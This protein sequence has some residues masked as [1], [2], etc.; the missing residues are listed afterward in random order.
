MN[1][2]TKRRGETGAG[3]IGTPPASD[4]CG[5]GFVAT[6]RGSATRETVDRALE[7]LRRLEH[8]GGR[9]AD[10][11]G[12]GAGIAASIPRPLL[13]A[14]ARAVGMVFLPGAPADA[15][16]AAMVIEDELRRAGMTRVRWRDVPCNNG[17]LGPSARERR[18]LIR[19]V[20]SEPADGSVSEELLERGLYIA[21]RRA[22]R[23]FAAGPAD[24]AAHV[25]S[26]SCRT[27]VYK[28]M[29]GSDELERFY[30]D[31]RD[32]RFESAAAVFH[33]RFS[34]NTAPSWPLVQPL[35]TTAHNGEFNTLAGNVSWLR[36]RGSGLGLG[37]FGDDAAD[38]LPVADPTDSDSATFDRLFELMV[39]SGRPLEAV[40]SIV[41]P[42]PHAHMPDMEPAARAMHLYH[43]E[44][45]EPWD[46]PAAVVF[47]DGRSV[48]AGLDRNGLRPFRYERTD[49]GWVTGGSE[50]GLT[51][52]GRVVDR[53]RLG[54]GHVLCIDL[55]T[56]RFR[57]NDEVT[58]ELSSRRPY[59]EW[60]G[61]RMPRR[62][63]GR[64][65]KDRAG[66]GVREPD[67]VRRQLA[68]GYAREDIERIIGPMVDAASSPVGSMGDDTP[69]AALSTKPQKLQRFFKQR[70]AQ[71]TNPPIDSIRERG[72]MSLDT[73]LGRYTD[74]LTDDARAMPCTR[75]A[76]PVIGEHDLVE[77]CRL[78]A[79][80]GRGERPV[81][82]DCTYDPSSR[83]AGL[84][85]AVERVAADALGA[86]RSG[87]GVVVL[88]D[89]RVGPGR[90]A[91][92]MLAAVG[93]AHE[94]LV[95]HG[96][97]L[98]CSLVCDTGEAREDHDFACL[99]GFGA[100]LVLPHVALDTIR[101]MSDER[102]LD[103][104]LLAYR[105]A[106]EAGLLKI[107]ARMGVTVIQSY[108]GAA[109]FEV[110][111]LDRDVRGLCF[112]TAPAFPGAVGWE[113]IAGYQSA[114]HGAAYGEES[115]GTLAERG[116]YRYRKSGETH[117]RAPTVFKAL[118]KSV[119]SGEAGDYVRYTEEVEALPPAQPRDLLRWAPLHEPIGLDEVEPVGEVLRRL[120][121][122]AMSHGALSREAHETI[123]VGAN[124][125]G[126]ASN[127]GEGGEARERLVPFSIN[128][129]TPERFAETTASERSAGG[130]SRTKQVAS[131]RFGV[132]HVY[133]ASAHELEIKMAQGAKPGEGG[134]IA[135]FK[136]TPE[137]A[138]IRGVEAGTPLISP[139]P[140][141]DIYSIE[142]LAQL[143]YDLKAVNPDA[144]V[145]VKLVSSLGIG[146]IACGVCK[147]GADVITVSGADG[148]TGAAQLSSI[149]HAGLPWEIGL[150]LVQRA[151]VESGLRDRVRVRADGGMA[152]GRDAVTAGLLGAD[153]VGFGTSVL[154]AAGCVMAR[155]CHDNTCPV[156]VATQD[157]KLRAK[158][159]GRPEHVA[160]FF[161]FVAEE[162]RLH[163]AALGVH[164][165]AE[166]TGRVDGLAVREDRAATLDV[167]AIIAEPR[168]G[169]ARRW[170]GRRNPTVRQDGGVGELFR[171]RVSRAIEGRGAAEFASP[172]RPSD[173]SIG[174][175][176]AGAIGDRTLSGRG[177]ETIV[178]RFS[179]ATGQSF[180]AFCA[181]PMTLELR[182][183]AQDGV[184]KSMSGG[185]IVIR[186]DEQIAGAPVRRGPQ[187][188][189]G[190]TALYGATGGELF[191]RGLL[192]D[193]FAVR[194][195][196]ATA[197]IEGCGDHGC[198][199]MTAG[200]VV[201][202]G[203]I[204]R[205]FA[206]G[207]TGGV[208]LVLDTDGY[209][210]RH[211][212][213]GLRS[214]AAC[215][216]ELARARELIGRHLELTESPL[217]ASL[218]D[219]PV[220]LGERLRVVAP[221]SAA[222]RAG[223]SPAAGAS[224][225]HD[226]PTSG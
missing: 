201:V 175:A 220:V 132:D 145:A 129:H 137:I 75:L 79:S 66:I 83:G 127:S 54:P 56:G 180:G 184:G 191:A 140:H 207:M 78:A 197:V 6:T 126:V 138:A 130:S 55:E 76:S 208:A 151:L 144:P 223:L 22:E 40:M 51:G 60:V 178:G 70:F 87:C 15:D 69:L 170:S 116:E 114:R 177:S 8:R 121:A 118:H 139:P 14:D 42:E 155:R 2:L 123:A 36:A 46:G 103:E 176:V 57:D 143:I 21:R 179:G 7:A 34:T 160:A 52:E 59:E 71:V 161:A 12:D 225:G 39:V 166:L 162:I 163:L 93:A 104:R 86:V 33:R 112:P 84:R 45:L 124:R 110:I 119:R 43:S 53:G 168:A 146:T 95:E 61:G 165:F 159:P 58:R 210:D 72:N 47:F 81:T 199:Y 183:V 156:G 141:H 62:R 9:S 35:R 77:L 219:D 50:A 105:S 157:E 113:E 133:L 195:S 17:A 10:G 173:R 108:R 213:G 171:D 194:N 24:H 1:D 88:S 96:V 187:I 181:E 222:A 26:L 150:S 186:P 13:G 109:L 224:V 214:A 32:P 82:V 189:A 164:R 37:P 90:A 185:R 73:S 74:V 148:G 68:F 49:D 188:I 48:G 196:G 106:V 154:I 218:L 134:Q 91:V 27:I 100:T 209:L 99:I 120:S 38:V 98:D 203:P 80:A 142:D 63:V 202:L 117:A 217:A 182:G 64:D 135:S 28:A 107:M 85:A 198:E 192:G 226:A 211:L 102:R 174:A 4:A 20:I 200:T 149:K 115:P 89:R 122:Q 172:V 216:D 221:R 67:L 101:T 128:G 19:Q 204:G 169:A 5:L 94:R 158:F 18:P 111:G 44:L 215:R 125:L 25:C 11:C 190:N 65:D 16:T 206:A 97:R 131:G 205:N 30:A 23:R 29:C 3:A 31:L 153:E 193:R 92:P 152:T 212:A 41:C 136:V 167:S 147:A